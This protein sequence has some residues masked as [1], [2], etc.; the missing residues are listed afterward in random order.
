MQRFTLE[1][2]GSVGITVVV[3]AVVLGIGASILNNL[4]SSETAGTA[5]YN[6]SGYGL[7]G[8]NTLA[9]YTPTIGIVAAA[10]VVIGILIFFFK[11]G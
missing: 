8:I 2:L 1:D 9:S 11:R 10:A 3:F 6:A 7:S 5:A 4:Q